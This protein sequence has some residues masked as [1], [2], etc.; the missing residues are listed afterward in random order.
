MV[1][2]KPVKKMT[3]KYLRRKNT[4][5]IIK[6]KSFRKLTYKKSVEKKHVV[7]NTSATVSFAKDNSTASG[8]ILVQY[9]STSN[10]N[11]GAFFPQIPIGTQDDNRIGNELC[12]TGMS[13]RIRIRGQP[14]FRSGGQYRIIIF[15]RKNNTCQFPIDP[16]VIMRE[17]LDFDT[18]ENSNVYTVS[19]T[20]NQEFYKNYRVHYNKLFSLKPDTYFSNFTFNQTGAPATYTIPEVDTFRDHTINLKLNRSVR[21]DKKGITTL[22]TNY[23][24]I[25]YGD[26]CLLLLANKGDIRI[27]GGDTQ[28]RTSGFDASW[29]INWYYVDS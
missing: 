14:N 26:M 5:R 29:Y 8:H 25:S 12:L 27:S 3:R 9:D 28:T 11:V 16:N 2:A 18:M 7:T 6:K 4:K 17:F 21:Y 20:R 15:S 24:P 19:S 13:M 22:P 10:T 1:R 23:N